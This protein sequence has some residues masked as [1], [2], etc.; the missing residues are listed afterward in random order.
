MK[1]WIAILTATLL[2]AVLTGCASTGPVES[3]P[4]PRLPPAPG[5]PPAQTAPVAPPDAAKPAPPPALPA[6]QPP[7]ARPPVAAYPDEPF[8]GQVLSV[9]DLLQPE[10]RTVKV[11][12]A[13]SNPDRRLKPGMFATVTFTERAAAA[14]V[15]PSAAVLL[16]GDASYV[17]VELSANV[18]QRRKVVPGGPQGNDQTLI[19]DG[20]RPGERVVT[21]NAVLLQ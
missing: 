6:P 5:S 20:L 12:M 1:R 2:S 14:L 9:G 7:A 17:F 4:S 8:C 13:L 16:L 18:Y 10:T 11:R 19:N 21:A 15:V 3:R